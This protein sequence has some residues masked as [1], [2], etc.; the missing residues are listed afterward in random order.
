MSVFALGPQSV[1]TLV[2]STGTKESSKCRNLRLMIK[3]LQAGLA[4]VDSPATAMLQG[5]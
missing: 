5:E 4:G 2:K 3:D 1:K